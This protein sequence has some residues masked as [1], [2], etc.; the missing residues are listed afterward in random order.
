MLNGKPGTTPLPGRRSPLQAVRAALRLL[1]VN[2][3]VFAILAE[4]LCIVFV[5]LKSWPS[6]RPTYHLN[7]NLFW[8]DINPDF[9]VWH[10]PNGHFDHQLGCF[11]VEYTTNGYGARDKERR[12]HSTKP[13][14]VVLGD[15]FIEGF[16]LPDQERLTNILERDTGREYLNFGT[17]GDFSPLQ[18]ALL[19]KTLASRFDHN[20]VLVG[21]LPDNDFYE[22]DPAW[23]RR[24]EPDRYRPYYASDLSVFYMG[25]FDPTGG[26]GFGDHVEAWMRAYLASYH[27]G[28]YIISRFYWRRRRVYSGYN[29]YTDVDLTRLKTALGDIKSTADAHR[30]KMAVFLIPRA[31]DFKRLHEA[32]ADRLG[33]VMEKWGQGVGI[34]I[35][36]LL[37]EMDAQS[38]GDN[39]SYF[40]ECDG[41]WSKRGSAVAA[42]IVENWLGEDKSVSQ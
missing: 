38:N 25:H 6:S 14:T 16:G 8:A 13:R 32:G 4:L 27:V 23:G 21:V 2:F 24:A 22:M 12:L 3:L 33:P 9:G 28:Q 10:R 19:Y 20:Q 18:Y 35:L 29:D 15:S 26:E 42:K 1:A 11:S 30:A 41:H 40:H 17:G 7:Y 36:D 31:N 39:R 37:P 5:H 34:P